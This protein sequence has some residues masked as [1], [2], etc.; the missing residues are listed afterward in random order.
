V[1]AIKSMRVLYF[2]AF[3]DATGR[4]EETWRS[5]AATAAELYAEVAARYRFPFD[6]SFL[7][8][9]RNDEVVAWDTELR[10]GDSVAFLAPFAGG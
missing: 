1:A 9:A 10:D 7:G 3:H 5:S 2:A 8:V 4:R 6:R